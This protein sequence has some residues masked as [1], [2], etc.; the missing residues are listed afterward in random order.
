QQACEKAMAAGERR[1]FAPLQGIGIM[2]VAVDLLR[3]LD[4]DLLTF[5]NLNTR[6][7][8]ER[9]EYLWEKRK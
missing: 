1:I 6:E 8:M 5:F 2:H 9:A 3:P 4:G 7:D